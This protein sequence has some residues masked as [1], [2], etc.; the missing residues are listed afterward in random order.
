VTRG[1]AGRI[2]GALRAARAWPAPARA[3]AVGLL[4]ALLPCGWL[5][6]FVATAGGTGSPAAG[7][8]TMAVFWL[9]TLPVMVVLGALAQGALGRVARYVPLVTSVVLLVFGLLTVFGRMTPARVEAALRKGHS[10]A[11]THGPAVPA[12]NHDC[13]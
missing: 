8:L 10:A 6:A 2:A 3:L 13:R 1:A 9:G 12:G 11:A 5:Y 4:S 7:A